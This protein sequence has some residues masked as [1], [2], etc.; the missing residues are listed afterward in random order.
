MNLANI[1]ITDSM[2]CLYDVQYALIVSTFGKD[3]KPYDSQLVFPRFG[4][5]HNQLFDLTRPPG[6]GRY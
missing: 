1:T 4:G 3:G 5:K 2:T 6:V